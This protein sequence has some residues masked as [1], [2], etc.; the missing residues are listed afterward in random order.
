M[1]LLTPQRDAHPAGP[2]ASAAPIPAVAKRRMLAAPAAALAVGAAACWIVAR[3][4]EAQWRLARVVVVLGVTA[5]VLVADRRRAGRARGALLI[6]WGLTGLVL[7]VGIGVP[8]LLKAGPLLTTAAGT[9][10][11]VCG[12]VLLVA[13]GAAFLRPM[14]RRGRAVTVTAL[15]AVV[16]LV[17]WSLGQAVAGTNVPP[18]RGDARTPADDGLSFETVTFVSADGVRLAGWYI[19][20]R[21]GAAVVLLH[22]AGSTR[23]GVLDEAVVLADHGYGVLLYDARG[24]GESDGRAMDFGWYGDADVSGAV[25]FLTDRPEVDADRIAAVGM[26]MGGEQALGASAADARIRAVVAEG[27][28]NRTAADWAWLSDR[29]GARGWLQE[30]VNRLTYLATDLLTEASPPIS[31]RDAAAASPR[32]VLLVTA[33][34]VPDEAVAAE[35]IRSAAPDTVRSWTVPG[36]G[37]TGG[38]AVRPDAW[39]AEVVGFLDAA[40]G[41]TRRG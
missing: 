22:G 19:P 13:G 35:F 5:T 7:G 39:T 11:G 16:W 24:H 3:D 37:H 9:V 26:S 28:T 1:A 29:Y 17:C 21:S 30:Q 8:H 27:A 14:R 33:G 23:S 20:S 36:A 4:G 6:G 31:L 25:S 18:T 34:Q 12:S 10:A 40:L 2:A 38:L 32:P 15:L 41:V